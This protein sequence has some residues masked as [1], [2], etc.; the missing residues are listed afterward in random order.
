MGAR[1]LL[2]LGVA[3]AVLV[4]ACGGQEPTSTVSPTLSP[5]PTPDPMI[6]VQLALDDWTRFGLGDFSEDVANDLTGE[7][8]L[9]NSVV[10]QAIRSTSS[11]QFQWEVASVRQAARGR[12]GAE[13]N[14]AGPLR[15]KLL[16]FERSYGLR[17]AY[18]VLIENDEVVQAS[19]ASGS[20]SLTEGTPTAMPTTPAPTATAGPTTTTVVQYCSTA[21]EGSAA[22]ISNAHGWPLIQGCAMSELRDYDRWV[23]VG[24]QFANAI[25]KQVFGDAISE[26]DEGFIIIR[27][28][29][30]YNYL[31][32]DRRVWGVAGWSS[33]DTLSAILYVIDNGLP[34]RNVKQR[35]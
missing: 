15:L 27:R 3:V 32:K 21:D 17:F 20:A 24:G 6:V 14:F 22:D 4:G 26:A 19:L 25:H 1:A 9:A 34:D 13:V 31:G 28:A 16:G 12:L 8:P 35:Y 33:S 11:D 30:S 29:N 10:A 2:I 18:S 5:T 23:L 7:L